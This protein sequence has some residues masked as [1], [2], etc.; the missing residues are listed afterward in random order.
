MILIILLMLLAVAAFGASIAAVLVWAV[1]FAILNLT[2]NR[3]KPLRWALPAVSVLLL[4]WGDGE[5]PYIGEILAGTVLLGWA[6]G[7]AAYQFA[8]GGDRRKETPPPR[9]SSGLRQRGARNQKGHG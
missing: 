4:C 2:P 3:L 7:W 1:Q 5:F 6:L 9:R 8:C